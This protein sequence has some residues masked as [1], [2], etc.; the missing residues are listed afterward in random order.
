MYIEDKISRIKK[1]ANAH[2]LRKAAITSDQLLRQYKL[3]YKHLGSGPGR[4]NLA[5]VARWYGSQ[6]AVVRASLEKAEPFTW[7]KHLDKRGTDASTRSPWHLSALIV[8]EFVHSQTRHDTMETIPEDPSSSP[9]STSLSPQPTSIP[10]MPPLPSRAS[11]NYSLGP[12]LSRMRSYDGH[13][14]FEPLVESLRN[15]LEVYSPPTGEGP[16]K[17]WRHSLPVQPNSSRSSISSIINGSS[18]H[19]PAMEGA[20]SPAS[21][22]LPLRDFAQRLLRRPPNYSDDGSSARNS[23]SELS[24]GGGKKS[25]MIR[26]QHRPSDLDL[27]SDHGSGAE[28]GIKIVISRE[29]SE[30][31]DARVSSNEGILTGN[32]HLSGTMSDGDLSQS[33]AATKSSTE[34]FSATPRVLQRHRVRISLPSSDQLLSTSE[35]RR[36]QEADDEQANHEYEL[37]AQ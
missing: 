27:P 36:Y 13:I 1:Q 21:N 4:L 20:H 6:E 14:S 32:V 28:T 19:N 25:R 18:N 23:L 3:V 31:E 2:T 15:S 24:E 11:S 37:K 5:S 10:S 34:P 35:Q 7:L 17:P 29:P 12:S 16:S 33:H 26:N 8:E 22:R 30:T 9:N